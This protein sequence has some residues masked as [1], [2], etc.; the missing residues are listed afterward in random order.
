M[1]SEKKMTREDLKKL[2][3]ELRNIKKKEEETA[4]LLAEHLP[5]IADD[6]AK[7]L[8][9]ELDNSGVSIELFIKQLNQ[10]IGEPKVMIAGKAT[11]GKKNKPA[12][13]SEVIYNNP[14]GGEGAT[15][16]GNPPSWFKDILDKKDVATL[17]KILVPGKTHTKKVQDLINEVK[18]KKTS[19]K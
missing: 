6:I 4:K 8:V 5:D 17:E 7:N 19:S 13:T 12:K 15:G 2:Q 1:A 11:S 14:S 3:E 10:H 16:R 9:T 18:A